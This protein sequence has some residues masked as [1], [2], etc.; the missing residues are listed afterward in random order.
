MR[1]WQEETDAERLRRR[2]ASPDSIIARMTND[3]EANLQEKQKNVNKTDSTLAARLRE[4]LG[5]E[6]DSDG[7]VRELIPTFHVMAETEVLHNFPEI[8]LAST[9]TH[10]SSRADDASTV[11]FSRLA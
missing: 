3:G 8:V 2:W 4:S 7:I 10:L 9:M 6:S 11:T 5:E 1:D